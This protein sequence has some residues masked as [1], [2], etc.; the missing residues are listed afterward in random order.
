MKDPK[1]QSGSGGFFRAENGFAKIILNNK[2]V[3]SYRF[4][5]N[6]RVEDNLKL[7]Y[8]MEINENFIEMYLI[9]LDDGINEVDIDLEALRKSLLDNQMFIEVICDGLKGKPEAYKA[10]FKELLGWQEV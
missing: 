9:A 2:D 6:Q 4:L 8:A 3:Q 5:K 1:F 7:M 10:Y